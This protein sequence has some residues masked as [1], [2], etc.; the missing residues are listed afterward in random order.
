MFVGLDP[1]VPGVYRVATTPIPVGPLQ[2]EAGTRFYF[3]FG[4]VGRA[5]RAFTDPE[6]IDTSRDQ[7]HYR[8]YYG[9]SVFKTL[10][11]KF[12]IRVAAQV[13]RA[14]FSQREIARTA[15]IAGTLR[16]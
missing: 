4:T 12:V 11:D 13:L 2:A 9:D 8:H 16:R 15:G 7:Q 1:V 3:D 5:A 14:V 6:K 10:G